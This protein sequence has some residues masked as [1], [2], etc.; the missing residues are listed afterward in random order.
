VRTILGV[1]GYVDILV[2]NAGISYR[3][4]VT[5]TSLEVD[6]KVMNINY[7]GTI[8]LTKGKYRQMCTFKNRVSDLILN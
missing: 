7:F 4:E 2:N 6:A 3:G 1:Y 8:G 5:D